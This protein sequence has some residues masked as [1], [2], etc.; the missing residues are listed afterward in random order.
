MIKI[1]QYREPYGGRRR[2]DN[3]DTGLRL[4]HLTSGRY[5]VYGNR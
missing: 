3:P 5:S 4:V 1:L 2:V